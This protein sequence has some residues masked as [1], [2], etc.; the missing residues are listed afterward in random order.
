MKTLLITLLALVSSALAQN[1][2]LA[3]DPKSA[4]WSEPMPHGFSCEVG[5]VTWNGRAWFHAKLA[6]GTENVPGFG[7]ANDGTVKV[8]ARE[9]SAIV[10]AAEV[11]I[12]LREKMLAAWKAVYEEMPGDAVWRMDQEKI[13][14]AHVRAG[15]IQITGTV[16]RSNVDG[17]WMMNL[18]MNPSEFFV[19]CPTNKI[20][21]SAEYTFWVTNAGVREIGGLKLQCYQAARRK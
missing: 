12:V 13:R 15:H 18:Q 5:T 20:A 2:P 8:S 16:L 17:A 3:L 1:P 21:D 14:L 7:W 9:G 6:L 11:P 19:F 4:T 10:R